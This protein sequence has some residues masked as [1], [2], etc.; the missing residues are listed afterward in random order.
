LTFI[1][2]YLI[3]ECF[4]KDFVLTKLFENLGNSNNLFI[5]SKSK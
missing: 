3:G 2:F 1:L 4:V 5:E